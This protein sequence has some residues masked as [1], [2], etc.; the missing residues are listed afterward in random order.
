[1]MRRL[2]SAFVT[3][4]KDDQVRCVRTY[5]DY[6]APSI[7]QYNK[8]YDGGGEEQIDDI[9]GDLVGEHVLI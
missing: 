9:F 8:S 2:Y 5:R 7:D 6:Q 3:C 4:I 1:M